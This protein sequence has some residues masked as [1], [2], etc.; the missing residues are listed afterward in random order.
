MDQYYTNDVEYKF[1]KSKQRRE[2][3]Q[4]VEKKRQKL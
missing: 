2:V 4:R 3:D 1:L